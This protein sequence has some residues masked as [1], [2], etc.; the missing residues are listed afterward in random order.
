MDKVRGA[1][2]RLA[3]LASLLL[4][5]WFLVGALGTKFGLLDWRVGFGLMTFKLGPLLIMGAL[6][7]AV[8][9]LLLALLV[10]P[11]R[12]IGIALIALLIPAAGLGYG[13]Y[14]RSQTQNIPPIHDVSTDLV[15]PPSFSSTVVDERAKVPDGNGLDLM[16]AKLPD[17]PRLG[18]MA[19]KPVLD[20]HRAAYG[21][22][23]PLTTD[24]PPIDTFQ[25]ALDA[26]EAQPGWTVDRHDAATGMI[27]ARATSFWYGFV[28]DIAIRVRPLPDNSG[29]MVDMRSVSRVGLSD[30]GANAKRVRAYMG[31]LNEKL[32]EAATGG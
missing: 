28:D 10:P 14:V 9:A 22:L 7:L 21:D 12:G 32:S 27:E 15:D 11:R 20:V 8:L 6:A 30:L 23:K 13:A 29:S 25:V 31:T 2:V 26:A 19:G 5:V 24:A 18:A 17:A 4:P 1:F 16:T 3:L